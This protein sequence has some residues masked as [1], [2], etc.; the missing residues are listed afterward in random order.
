[1]KE[2]QRESGFLDQSGARLYY[3]VA[4][5]GFPLL[6]IHAGVAD[7]RMWD[8][9]F[10]SFAQHYRV[11]R[12]DLRGYGKTDVSAGTFSSYGDIADLFRHLGVEKAHVLGISY[13]GRVG[14]DFTLAHP[15]MVADLILVTPDIS[16]RP[17]SAL[18][19]QFGMEEDAYLEKGDLVG[20]TELN[21]RMWVDGPKRSPAQVSSQVRERVRQMQ[22][23]AFTIAIPAGVEEIEL[24]PSA[25][26]R[27]AEVQ[28]PTLLIVGDADIPDKLVTVD[29]LAAAIPGAQR[30]IIPD[31]AHMVNMEKPEEF[32]RLV[33][34]FLAQH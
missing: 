3:E 24:T 30:V 14:L 10:D 18:A 23:H 25:I 5:E 4:G 7:S 11:I 21:L 34:E 22:M 12:Y 13:G 33:L 2:G 6:L 15:E 17:P 32:N 16:G 31:V 19:Q 29:E 1:M 8:E 26:N 28:V 20:A 9:Q 27:L